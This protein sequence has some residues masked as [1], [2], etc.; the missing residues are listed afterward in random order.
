MPTNLH[1]GPIA[2]KASPAAVGRDEQKPGYCIDSVVDALP[3]LGDKIRRKGYA[4]DRL[5]L[6]PRVDINEVQRSRARIGEHSEVVA[7]DGRDQTS[8]GDLLPGGARFGLGREAVIVGDSGDANRLRDD[9]LAYVLVNAVVGDKD[10]C[11]GRTGSRR[12]LLAGL[13]HLAGARQSGQARGRQAAARY[14]SWSRTRPA[15]SARP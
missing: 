1:S 5:C 8:A 7:D 11:A 3:P 6:K 12:G 4:A 10:R 14:D 9:S 13:G 2:D 15:G